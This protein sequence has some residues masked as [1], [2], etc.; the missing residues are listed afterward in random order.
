MLART[1]PALP[2]GPGWAYEPKFDGYRVL[3]FRSKT[4]CSCSPASSGC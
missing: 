4:G 1:V 3:A 2:V